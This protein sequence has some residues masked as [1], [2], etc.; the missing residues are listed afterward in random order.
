MIIEGEVNGG[1]D[2]AVDGKVDGTIDLPQHASDG[3]RGSPRVP[4]DA[5]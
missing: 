5:W 4:R 1:E 3:P 2:L